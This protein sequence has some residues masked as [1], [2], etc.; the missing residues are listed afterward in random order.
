[1]QSGSQAT[2]H[3]GSELARLKTMDLS[4]MMPVGRVLNM[5][6]ACTFPPFPGARFWVAGTEYDVKVEITR[7][8]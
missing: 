4:E 2:F 8:E 3:L 6:R 1:P 7:V 5:L